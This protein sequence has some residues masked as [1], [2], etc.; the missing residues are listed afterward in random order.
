MIFDVC[1]NIKRM[2]EANK[3]NSLPPAPTPVVVQAR[4][5][6]S[7]VKLPKIDVLN[8]DRT[9]LNYTSFREQ[10]EESIHSKDQLSVAEKLALA[11]LRHAVKDSPAKHVI[12]QLESG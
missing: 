1:L 3:P 10:F 8:F 11:H 2:L 9:M 5:Q 7:G 6:A 12:G 4:S